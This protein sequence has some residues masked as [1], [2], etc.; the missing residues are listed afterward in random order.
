MWERQARDE[1]F[2]EYVHARGAALRRT[3][4]HLCAGDEAAAED[5]LQNSLIRTYR[6]WDQVRDEDRR[7]AYVRRI[8][9]RLSFRR[10]RRTFLGWHGPG[11]TGASAEQQLVDRHAVWAYLAALPHRQRAVIVLRY[12]EDLSEREIAEVLGCSTGTVKTHASRALATLR[13]RL[14]Q[15]EQEET[16]HEHG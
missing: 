16:I 11:E 13:A 5:L 10:E 4:V 12:Y 6:S 14:G 3:A 9:V 8:M 1:V 7:D 15:A 2:T